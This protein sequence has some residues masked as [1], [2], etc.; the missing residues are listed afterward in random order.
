MSPDASGSEA[1]V[2]RSTR[3]F[4]PWGAW[5]ASGARTASANSERET[6]R[7][8][9]SPLIQPS[10]VGY[11]YR[12]FIARGSEMDLQDRALCKLAMRRGFRSGEQRAVLDRVG[13][14]EQP[15]S[16]RKRNH[17]ATIALACGRLG[18]KSIENTG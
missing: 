8:I 4:Q 1:A 16:R 3:I 18:A 12:A 17:L 10:W 7:F 11:H 5:A 9:P 13:R 15:R 2:L 14:G 6:Q